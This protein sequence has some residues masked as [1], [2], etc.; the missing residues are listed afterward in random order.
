[1][2]IKNPEATQPPLTPESANPLPETPVKNPAAGKW[3]VIP[4]EIL[5]P[6]DKPLLSREEARKERRE[7]VL[8]NGT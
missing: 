7:S 8:R 4:D 3:N 5:P 1:M 6:E 2:E